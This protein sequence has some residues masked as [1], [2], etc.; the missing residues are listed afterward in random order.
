MAY[1]RRKANGRFYVFVIIVAA[2]VLAVFFLIRFSTGGTVEQ[3]SIPLSK[4]VTTVIVR[5]EQVA[6]AETY[7]N[8]KF[9]ATEGEHV[10]SGAKV[11]EVYK[12]GYN[13][14][15]VQ[16]LLTLQQEIKTYQVETILKDIVDTELN[17]INTSIGEKVDAIA[18]AV[19]GENGDDVL[20]LERDLERMMNDR[21]DLL[22]TKVQPDDK[23][24]EMY[25]KEQT[26]IESIAAL[27]GDA[28]S[29]GTGLIS[30]YFDGYETMLNGTTVANLTPADISAALK[31]TGKTAN[32]DAQR[33]LYRIV[34]NN[35]WYCTMIDDKNS[36]QKLVMGEKYSVVFEG[37]FDRPYTGTLIA[38]NDTAD[39]LIYTLEIDEDIGPFLSVRKS[40]ASIVRTFEGLRIPSRVITT[41]DGKTGVYVHANGG[42]Q[43]VEIEVLVKNREYAIVRAKDASA[44]L[45]EG[46]RVTAN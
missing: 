34:N 39:G 27:K 9:L 24:T 26:L 46:V 25:Q 13:E 45:A 29:V 1:R 36:A 35:R 37:Y 42:K 40:N 16:D 44:P 22:R 17:T 12:W 7:G 15:F 6:T 32:A 23:L 30:F 20:L 21:S 31:G 2:A 5:D 18:S 11:A 43:Y 3:G 10:E 41:K 8:I 14:N 19:R 38:A 33:P 4:T 28:L